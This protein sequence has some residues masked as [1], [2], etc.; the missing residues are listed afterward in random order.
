[1]ERI[2]SIYW[3]TEHFMERQWQRRVDDSVLR[4]VLYKINP[5]SGHRLIV[6]SREV[7]TRLKHEVIQEELVIKV[8]NRR[9]ITCFFT[10]YQTYRNHCREENIL[11]IKWA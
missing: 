9:L 6:V 11:V 5:C 7:L 10:D 1:M 4:R 3:K 2:I 8:E